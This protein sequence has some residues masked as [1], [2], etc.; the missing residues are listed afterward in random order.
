[1]ADK[2][3][4]IKY[5][6]VRVTSAQI[7]ALVAEDVTI[8]EA[9]GAGKIIVPLWALV[10]MDAGSTPYTWVEADEENPDH[11][12]SLGDMA[13]DDDTSVN[14]LITAATDY[15]VRLTPLA[16]STAIT[17]NTALKLTASGVGEP[18]LGNGT[19]VVKVAYHV[20]DGDV[21]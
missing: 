10:T 5:K 8:V 7:K 21:V 12:I 20:T 2:Q 15:S 14:A 19:L 9:P 1:M 3:I 16:G 18:T 13:L 11:A 17:A 6:Q 4:E